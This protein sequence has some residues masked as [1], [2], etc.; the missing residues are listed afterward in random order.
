MTKKD[1][2][3]CKAANKLGYLWFEDCAIAQEQIVA[4]WAKTSNETRFFFSDKNFL[5]VHLP[6]REVFKEIERQKRSI[7]IAHKK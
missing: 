2:E 5:T 6:I 4:F 7:K 3:L 1:K